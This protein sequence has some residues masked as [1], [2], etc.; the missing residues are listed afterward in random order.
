MTVMFQKKLPA[1]S[2]DDDGR[3]LY[4]IAP[5]RKKIEQFPTTRYYGSKRKL[6][7][8][9]FDSLKLLDFQTV[10]D[11]FGGTGSVS[12]L[13][14][15]MRKDV[16][17]HDAFRFNA[18]IATAILTNF[19][20]IGGDKLDKFLSEVTPAKGHVSKIFE[21]VFFTDAENEWIDGFMQ[22]IGT[23][24]FDMGSKSVFMY[25]LYQACL[26]KRPFNLFH[27]S[28][29]SVRT[30]V[31][32]KRS[33]GNSTTWER[34]F[35][36]HMSEGY[37]ELQVTRGDRLAPVKILPSGDVSDLPAGFD[38][39]YLD[40]PYVSNSERANR[41]NYWLRYHFLEGLSDYDRWLPRIVPSSKIRQME[42]PLHFTEWSKRK[43][44]REKLF[45]LIE[46]HR[47][48]IVV[49]SYVKNAYPDDVEIR[50]FFEATFARVSVHS[51]EHSHAL[52]ASKKR[53]LLFVGVPS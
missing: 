21:G 46:K 10:L 1:I 48:S 12:Q 14:R 34:S 26:K 44:F 43:T 4:S 18:D 16:S 20:L 39:V 7:P 53:E 38:L 17:Y 37:R 15:A 33:F 47:S 8:W 11:G 50:E 49:L 31:D 6:L 51:T 25:L 29:L 42:E 27:R 19:D 28:N 22:R 40:P 5:L 3:V 32:V 52:S 23:S 2:R 35:V 36:D 24:G 41:D 45:S 13:F 9:L 30:N